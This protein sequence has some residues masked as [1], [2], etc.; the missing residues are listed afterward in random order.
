MNSRPTL[1]QLKSRWNR[2]LEATSS[3]VSDH[4]QAYREL[5]ALLADT[6]GRQV[7]INDYFP[8]VER[9]IDHLNCLDPMGRE[10]IFH[11]FRTRISPSSIWDVKLLRVEC[12]DL[13]D[14]LKVFDEW[15]LERHHLKV[16]K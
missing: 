6:I 11:H 4:P 12:R 8:T 9:L 13:M 16:I 2:T 14:H 15:R 3:S 7:D 5:K 1:T 10:S